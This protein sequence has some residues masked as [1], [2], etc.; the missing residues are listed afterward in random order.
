MLSLNDA[1][2]G[3]ITIPDLLGQ[4]LIVPHHF[5]M[6]NSKQEI[7]QRNFRNFRKNNFLSNHKK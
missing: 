4:F 5:I 2:S 1:I 3:N 6:P 7:F